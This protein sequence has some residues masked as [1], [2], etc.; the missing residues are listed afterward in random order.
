VFFS[1]VTGA[2]LFV[3][4]LRMGAYPLV[5][6]APP[7]G[8]YDQEAPP[9]VEHGR[10]TSLSGGLSRTTPASRQ[11]SR[12]L[13]FG[14]SIFIILLLALASSPLAP[15]SLRPPVPALRSAWLVLHVTFAFVG[16]AF[17]AVSFVA[18]VIFL[19]NTDAEKKR[20]LDRIIYTTIAIGYPT[21]TAGALIF[22]AVWAQ[23]AWGRY[24]GWDPK[25]TWALVTW[26]VYTLYLHFR[27]IRHKTGTI[28]ALIALTGFL[29][30]MFTFLGVNFLLSGKHSYG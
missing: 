12:F 8:N 5:R 30:T 4:R 28:P 22:G 2:I 11:S 18:S 27:F 3:Y 7:G 14:G 21:F 19:F 25:E 17:F 1:A 13:L 20:A 29:L 10:E 15:G 26:L 9:F 23:F 6:E 24:W 16:E